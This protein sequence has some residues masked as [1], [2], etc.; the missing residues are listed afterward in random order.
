MNDA[1]IIAH[2]SFKLSD[3]AERWQC[4]VPTVKR[5][6]HEGVL[7]GFRFGNS[8]RFT[9]ADILRAESAMTVDSNYFRMMRPAK[10]APGERKQLSARH[11][12]MLRQALAKARQRRIAKYAALRAAKAEKV[13]SIKAT[14]LQ[15]SVMNPKLEAR[16][17]E[18]CA[19][20]VPNEYF[21][22]NIT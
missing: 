8:L 17:S 18:P 3:V 6:Y 14:K 15:W 22:S 7:R 11:R 19:S 10:K 5:R 4:C 13:K 9:L 2:K 12:E 20:K 16:G 1:V 21:T